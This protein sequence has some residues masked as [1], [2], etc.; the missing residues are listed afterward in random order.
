MTQKETRTNRSTGYRFHLPPQGADALFTC[1]GPETTQKLKQFSPAYR[2]PGG[3]GLPINLRTGEPDEEMA[4]LAPKIQGGHK[5]FNVDRGSLR[6]ALSEDLNVEFGKGYDSHTIED[7]GI[8][9]RFHDGSSAKGSLLVGAD[10][11]RSK[12]RHA[13]L[14][15]YQLLD[16]TGRWLWGKS[17][18]TP[19][20]RS[21]LEP[22]ERGQMLLSGIIGGQD[23]ESS[24]DGLPISLICESMVFD[25]SADN[26]RRDDLPED[27]FYW[28]LQFSKRTVGIPD[29]DFLSLDAAGAVKLAQE[30]TKDWVPELRLVFQ[31]ATPNNAAAQ[32]VTSG[33]PAVPAYDGQGRI[34]LLGDAIHSMPPTAGAGASSALQDAQWLAEAIEEGG[35]TPTSLQ[36]YEARM[37]KNGADYIM[38]SEFKSTKMYGAP[39]FADMRRFKPDQTLGQESNTI[40]LS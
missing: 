14:E 37:R 13:L 28:V 1:L 2:G 33:D 11:V 3:V 35:I 18:I 30:L 4:K 22:T 25:R 29:S 8:D 26:S 34:A 39:L 21:Q 24:T 7:D 23:R 17:I 19:E 10:G 12:I 15:N 32:A 16:T 31:H 5:P 27:Y 36:K 20:L 38:S 6:Q 40:E 9:V